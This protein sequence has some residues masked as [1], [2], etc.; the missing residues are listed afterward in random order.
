MPQLPYSKK[1]KASTPHT[2]GWVSPRT[3]LDRYRKLAPLF[4]TPTIQHTANCYTVYTTHPPNL[5]LQIYKTT[6]NKNPMPNL[7]FHTHT[8]PNPEPMF[9]HIHTY[10]K[11]E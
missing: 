8:N 1:K 7:G 2:A 3:S 6:G 4:K 10:T 11:P 9:I 5:G